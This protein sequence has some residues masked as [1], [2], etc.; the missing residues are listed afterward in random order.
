MSALSNLLGFACI[1]TIVPPL[2]SASAQSTAPNEAW[3]VQAATK[4]TIVTALSG[5]VP[6]DLS[7]TL[8]LGAP[9]AN[10]QTPMEV[11]ALSIGSPQFKLD[12]AK[13]L[14]FLKASI[15]IPPFATTS[16]TKVEIADIVIPIGV[17]PASKPLDI[18]KDA[19]PGVTMVAS[20][21]GLL[22]MDVYV[23]IRM[24]FVLDAKVQDAATLTGTATFG[25]A[26]NIFGSSFPLL[27][28][29]PLTVKQTTAAQPFTAKKVPGDTTCAQIVASR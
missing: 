7:Y 16:G 12:P 27:G 5:E 17:D 13:L 8:K 11:C 26:G 23:G 6:A 19:K 10:G 9:D 28:P 22:N 29:G 24:S 14:P 18:D 25:V 20:A 4:A 1:L 2:T 3:V 21:L 15:T